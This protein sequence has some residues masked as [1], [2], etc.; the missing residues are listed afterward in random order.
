MA[1]ELLDSTQVDGTGSRWYDW[2][3]YE[4]GLNPEPSAFDYGGSWATE[5]GCLVFFD[6]KI[7]AP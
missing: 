1:D 3:N 6:T 4:A 7:R 5:V 2:A